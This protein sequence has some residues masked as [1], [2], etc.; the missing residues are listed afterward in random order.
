MT[1]ETHLWQKSHFWF[2]TRLLWGVLAT[3]GR[4]SLGSHAQ[5]Q[6]LVVVDAEHADRRSTDVGHSKNADAIPAEMIL[7]A[8]LAGVK[9]QGHGIRQRIDSRDVRP[10]VHITVDAST[11]VGDLSGFTSLRQA[12]LKHWLAADCGRIYSGFRNWMTQVWAKESMMP[13]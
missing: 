12:N 4:P 1:V 10:L 5:F 3:G 8:L 9:Q 6:L 7:P 2:T 11:S 13:G